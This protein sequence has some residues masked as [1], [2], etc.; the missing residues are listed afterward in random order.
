MRHSTCRVPNGRDGK[1]LERMDAPLQDTPFKMGLRP[2]RG[3]LHE[4]QS[5]YQGQ[6]FY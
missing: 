4:K 5:H 2:H 6:L 1:L 3:F